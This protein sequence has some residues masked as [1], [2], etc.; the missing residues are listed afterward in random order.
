MFEWSNQVD[1]ELGR[2][3]LEDGLLSVVGGDR[4]WSPEDPRRYISP[5]V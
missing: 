2:D 4:I 1:S 5:K 3:F